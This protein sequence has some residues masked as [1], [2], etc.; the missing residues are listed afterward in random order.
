MC[1]LDFAP[2]PKQGGLINSAFERQRCEGGNG[3]FQRGCGTFRCHLLSKSPGSYS[4]KP[5]Y[6]WGT[7]PCSL[8]L[9]GLCFCYV[10]TTTNS[11]HP[12]RHKLKTR[13]RGNPRGP[14]SRG[15]SHLS[16]EA[17]CRPSITPPC[18]QEVHVGKLLWVRQSHMRT[19]DT[20]PLPLSLSLHT[21]VLAASKGFCFMHSPD[22]E[23]FSHHP[24][25]RSGILV[26]E[27]RDKQFAQ[28][29]TVPWGRT[30]TLLLLWVRSQNAGLKGE[31]WWHTILLRLMKSVRAQGG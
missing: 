22:P 12:S 3:P 14:R 2:D 29:H 24:L 28:V 25:R 17:L 4:P 11:Y 6:P 15:L 26:L 7:H 23:T 20:P 10:V 27:G 30:H 8:I 9:S 19:A 1:K 5:L 16:C 13:G 18:K 31:R 21:S